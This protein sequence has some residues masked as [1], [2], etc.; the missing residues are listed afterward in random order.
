M[1]L[2]VAQQT[3][4]AGLVGS[5]PVGRR[6]VIQAGAGLAQVAP[7]V[8][9]DG[10]NPVG[11]HQFGQRRADQRQRG[12]HRVVI[13]VVGADRVALIVAFEFGRDAGFELAHATGHEGHRV[14]EL[15]G[16]QRVELA[17][18]DCRALAR[19]GQVHQHLCAADRLAQADRPP[20]GVAAHLNLAGQIDQRGVDHGGGRALHGV[21]R[22]AAGVVAHQYQQAAALQA[23]R[24]HAAGYGEFGAQVGNGHPNLTAL[25]DHRAVN[26][27]GAA[28]RG[29]AQHLQLGR[30]R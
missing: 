5:A 14:A 18:V 7:G 20:Q 25:L 8:V 19:G 24:A 11:R 27:E 13:E 4:Q 30:P 12:R 29:H 2:Q 23:G 26:G 16:Q 3:A 15:V 22:L 1:G 9:A 17:E 6:Q 28:Q 10:Q 21:A